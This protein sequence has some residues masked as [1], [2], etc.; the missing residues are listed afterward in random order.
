MKRKH[1]EKK[2][3]NRGKRKF[4]ISN[5]NALRAPYEVGMVL[6]KQTKTKLAQ[7]IQREAKQLKA[8]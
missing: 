1:T 7:A 2:S 5:C 4:S 6:G 8:D 3:A